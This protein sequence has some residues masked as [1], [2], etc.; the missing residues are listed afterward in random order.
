MGEEDG[1]ANGVAE[2]DALGDEHGAADCCAE[3]GVRH[4]EQLMAQLMAMHSRG[5]CT[6]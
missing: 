5:R 1:A 4:S 2:G 6:G 3:G